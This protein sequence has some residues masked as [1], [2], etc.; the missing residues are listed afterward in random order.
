MVYI[1]HILKCL[2]FN[3]LHQI[4]GYSGTK[5]ISMCPMCELLWLFLSLDEKAHTHTQ[6]ALNKLIVKGIQNKGSF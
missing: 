1:F 5:S 3:Y 2:D 6:T 4:H